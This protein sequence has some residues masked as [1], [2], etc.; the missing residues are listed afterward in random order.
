MAAGPSPILLLLDSPTASFRHRVVL[1]R[2][3]QEIRY[4]K[5]RGLEAT[6][7]ETHSRPMSRRTIGDGTLALRWHRF[8]AIIETSRFD[9][10]RTLSLA[11][12]VGRGCFW[13]RDRDGGM[14]PGHLTLA[15]ECVARA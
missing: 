10:L 4:A 12:V 3:I 15:S 8:V 9:G 13:L 7:E 14:P 1:R 5:V 6:G 11:A 2:T